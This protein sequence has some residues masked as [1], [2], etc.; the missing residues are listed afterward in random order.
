VAPET[1]ESEDSRRADVVEKVL[2]VKVYYIQTI[3]GGLL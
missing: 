2:V 3:T 1:A